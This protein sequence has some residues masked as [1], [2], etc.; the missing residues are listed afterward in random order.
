M[1]T[2][3]EHWDRYYRVKAASRST[4][5]ALH[6]SVICVRRLSISFFEKRLIVCRINRVYNRLVTNKLN[7]LSNFRKKHWCEC[8]RVPVRRIRPIYIYVLSV[9]PFPIT[10]I[11]DTFEILNCLGEGTYGKVWKCRNKNSQHLVAIKE[12][13]DDDVD[14]NIDRELR[15]ITVW[16]SCST[17]CL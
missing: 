9:S 13:Q 11:M 10:A 12:F 8:I 7:F 14:R 3:A 1:W 17:Y 5:D 4:I 6:H 16:Y 2:I 15:P